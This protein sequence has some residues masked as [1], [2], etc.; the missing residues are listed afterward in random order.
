MKILSF[1]ALPL[2]LIVDILTQNQKEM[3]T[4][5]VDF[6]K[7]IKKAVAVLKKN[8]IE[9][10]QIAQ[11]HTSVAADEALS[12]VFPEVLRHNAFKDFVETR[13]L[14]WLYIEYGAEKA[15]FSIGIF[16]MKPSFIEKMEARIQA[17][18]FQFLRRYDEIKPE[19]DKNKRRERLNR[20]KSFRWQMTYALAFRALCDEVFKNMTF[21]NR[22]EKINFFATAY[23]TGFEKNVNV[24]NQWTTRRAFPY[25]ATYRGNQLIYGEVSTTF[26]R[27]YAH[28]FFP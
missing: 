6:Q 10:T 7:D 19:N 23:N 3:P 4:Q 5:S 21:E 11:K 12:I 14:E 26:L 18:D 13:S 8:K 28:E 27:Q 17:S 15:D 24:L 1:C 20:L 2:F 9:I 25:G 22:E 16:Q